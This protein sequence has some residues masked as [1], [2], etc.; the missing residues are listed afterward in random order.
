MRTVKLTLTY[1]RIVLKIQIKCYNMNRNYQN[2]S[3]LWHLKGK[4]NP[5]FKKVATKHPIKI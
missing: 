1:L 3:C 5:R 2:Q 4:K